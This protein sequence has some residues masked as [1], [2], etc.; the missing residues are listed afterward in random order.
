MGTKSSMFTGQ[1]YFT[2]FGAGD[3]TADLGVMNPESAAAYNALQRINHLFSA[4]KQSFEQ[5]VSHVDTYS[6]EKITA[7]LQ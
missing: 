5:N 7:S 3:R 1:R 2:K 4:E 6:A